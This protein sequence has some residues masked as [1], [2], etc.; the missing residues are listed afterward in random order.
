MAGRQ[1]AKAQ[2]DPRT[3]PSA[4]QD[5]AAADWQAQAERPEGDDAMRTNTPPE[6]PA[7]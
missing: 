3:P 6:T 7:V 4:E 5:A 1:L 2:A